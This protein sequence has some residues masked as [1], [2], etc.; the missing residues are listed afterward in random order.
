MPKGIMA[1][2]IVRLSEY[3]AQENDAPLIWRRGAVFGERE[4]RAEVTHRDDPKSGVESINIRVQGDAR[5]KRELLT[6]ISHELR[7]IHKRSFENIVV[8]EW[9]PCCGPVCSEKAEPKLFDFK[10]IEETVKNGRS[11]RYCTICNADIS[12]RKM[13]EG[14]IDPRQD[15]DTND[16]DQRNMNPIFNVYNSVKNVNEVKI[17]ISIDIK[18]QVIAEFSG[19]L[20]NLKEDLLDE[21]E[22]EKEKAQVAKEIGK[23]EQAIAEIGAV[24]T[25]EEAK[26][27]TG[28]L[29]RI[30]KF[31]EKLQ[32]GTTTT[33]K[34]I[35]ALED[36]ISYAQDLAALYNKIAPWAAMPSVP[37]VFL[38]K[39]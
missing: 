37:D 39:K 18:N 32:D 25:P 29:S 20:E 22:G 12:I 34:A 27:K 24:S 36:G 1:R 8:N 14:L 13:L 6:I 16:F 3:V 15:R 26:T 35:G 28:A 19:L 11:R 23:V 30:K 33:G 21:I 7:Q 38:K 10:E 9:V 31:V 5:S 17:D 2:L 4:T